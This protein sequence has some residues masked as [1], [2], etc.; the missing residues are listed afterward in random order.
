[1]RI[2]EIS[3]KKKQTHGLGI[4][5]LE[6]AGRREE[7]KIYSE[8]KREEAKKKGGGKTTL[9]WVSTD[10][11]ILSSNIECNVWS[12]HRKKKRFKE[13][14]K[15]STIVSVHDSRRGVGTMKSSRG[16]REIRSE[17]GLG[18]LDGILGRGN[19]REEKGEEMVR[20]TVGTQFYPGT[21]GNAK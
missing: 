4:E 14:K 18:G 8:G 12:E 21:S 11:L 5:S 19:T 3:L 7:V 20:A 15:T 6:E 1:L 9:S 16:K 10:H 13:R 17:K 2:D